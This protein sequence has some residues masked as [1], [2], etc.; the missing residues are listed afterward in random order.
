MKTTMNIGSLKSAHPSIVSVIYEL[1]VRVPS[2]EREIITAVDGIFGPSAL[3]LGF[4]FGGSLII[5]RYVV[6]TRHCSVI[7]QSNNNVGSDRLKIDSDTYTVDNNSCD[8]QE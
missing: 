3:T 5:F 7:R 6:M 1:S 8:I 4:I 2:G